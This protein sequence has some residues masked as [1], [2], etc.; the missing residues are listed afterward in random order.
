MCTENVITDKNKAM[1]AHTAT[2]YIVTTL[3]TQQHI[4]LNAN[5][6]YPNTNSNPIH[7]PNS[8]CNTQKLTKQVKH[9]CISICK[10]AAA[11]NCARVQIQPAQSEHCFI[12]GSIWLKEC[13][14]M[15]RLCDC[16][17]Y[18]IAIHSVHRSVLLSIHGDRYVTQSGAIIHP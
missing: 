12:Y 6:R 16:T 10:H 15:R 18:K 13:L 7:N 17:Q 4:M 2:M 3:A 11:H 14:D 5:V 8:N 9:L 1:L